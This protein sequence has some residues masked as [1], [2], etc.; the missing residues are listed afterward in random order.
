MNTFC[1]GWCSNI[2]LNN[3]IKNKE[4][5]TDEQTQWYIQEHEIFSKEKV[6]S[7]KLRFK[8]K[9]EGEDSVWKEENRFFNGR[10]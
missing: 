1:N 9:D 8:L 4:N 5:F 3:I 10:W 2:V 6:C 7:D